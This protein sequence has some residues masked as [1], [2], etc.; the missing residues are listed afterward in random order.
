[1]QT[2]SIK[3]TIAKRLEVVSTHAREDCL[4]TTFALREERKSCFENIL[5]D[6]PLAI[7]AR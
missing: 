2:D 3:S 7:Q 6:K 5:G 4:E 1:M